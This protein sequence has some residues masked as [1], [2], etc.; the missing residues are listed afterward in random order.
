MTSGWGGLPPR[1][2]D[3]AYHPEAVGA[4]P[5]QASPNVI[6]RVVIIYGTNQGVFLYQG[7][8]SLGNPPVLSLTG[9]D[10]TTDPYGNP[11][12][13]DGYTVYEPGGVQAIFA[14]LA[15]GNIP[16]IQVGTSGSSLVTINP[17][18]STP[19]NIT[20]AIA[21]TLQSAL[22][23]TTTDTSE[24]IAG[25]LGSV[26]L[27]SG[28][29]AKM[30]TVLTSPLNS[31]TGAALALQCENDGGT[32]TA[33]ITLGTITTPDDETEIFSPILALYP[34]ALILYSGASGQTTVTKT[35]G[36]GTISGLPAT[37]KAEAWAPGGGGA[38]AASFGAA[39]AG[40]GEYAQEPALATSGSV[41]YSVGSAGTGGVNGG[42]ASTDGGNVTITGSAVTVTAHGGKKGTSTNTPGAG[43]TGSSN[44]VHY[45]GG[46]GAGTVGGGPNGAGG[47]G[48]AGTSGPGN[49]GGEGKTHSAG[50]GGAAVTGGGAGGSGG[51]TGNN[52]QPGTAPGGGGGGSSAG[53]NGGSGSRG[54]VRVTYTSGAPPILLSVAEQAG[55]DQFG[56]AY[57]AGFSYLPGDGNTY[58]S[59]PALAVTSGTQGINAEAQTALTGLSFDV[60]PGNYYFRAMICFTGNSN[61]QTAYVAMG[62]TCTASA[63]IATIDYS[64]AASDVVQQT[65]FGS[66][67]GLESAT[68]AN[69]GEYRAFIEGF[70]TVSTAGT[71]VVNGATS[72][73]A[74]GWTSQPGSLLELIPVSGVTS[75]YAPAPGPF[76]LMTFVRPSGDTSGATDVTSLG[77]ALAVYSA[78]VLL[79]GA[80]YLDATV[81]LSTA[82]TG[83][84]M[85]PGVV[86][87]AAAGITGSLLAIT[88]NSCTIS[89]I[90]QLNGLGA[91]NGT[92]LNGVEITG[93]QHCQIE[94]IYATNL[95]GYAVEAV[96]NAAACHDLMIGRVVGRNCAGGVH[97]QGASASSY[98][99]EIFI[100]DLQLQQIGAASGGNPN[101]DA[102]YLQDIEDVLIE[103]IN[104]GMVAGSG[105]C[106]DIAGACA[107]VELSNVDI[108][109]SSENAVL[110]QDTANGSPVN[111]IMPAGV[112]QEST[113][114]MT[115]SGGCSNSEFGLR[116]IDNQT[117]GVVLSGSGSNLLFQK[118][119]WNL[120]GQ[121]GT[122]T[123]YDFYVTGTATGRVKEC[124]F[125]TAIV[126][127][128][129]GPGVQGAVSLPSSGYGI[130]F[131]N[132]NFL[133]S[134]IS[135]STAFVANQPSYFR[136]CKNV[137]PHGSTTDFG[138][139]PSS[140]SSTTPLH[141]D[142][143][144]YVTAATGGCTMQR[145]TSG[146][147]GAASPSISVAA[148]TTL[149]IFVTAQAALMVT[150]TNA[151]T[152]QADGI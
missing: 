117:H 138:G 72:A 137:N 128:G 122:G 11:V 33:V 73:N 75:V 52:G 109:G 114:G 46:A 78:V 12:T 134:G 54:Q 24:M 150:Y 8:P 16:T 29:A 108:G 76:G 101:I 120:N 152:I 53:R 67:T 115:V 15:A 74:L 37:V 149:P 22:E 32:D 95:A 106:V 4:A 5:G 133:G 55:T 119:T 148:G 112:A 51:T 3:Q 84:V 45:D 62:G 86:I 104:I 135:P 127:S 107:T 34:Y 126:A 36:S 38:T 85:T 142:A 125:L 94:N 17:D 42:A 100:T 80:W 88:A 83:L 6:A 121:A 98:Q 132:V 23:L 130:P 118:C 143:W 49:A 10:T 57:A 93:A 145:I 96:G 97:L 79:P 77:A 26:L 139:V 136:N 61:T 91:T 68:L 87:N 31:S 131:T 39:S 59:G 50:P 28:T 58:N 1:R 56:T 30:T 27:N 82:S 141:Y 7:P 25:L 35:S 66:N 102:V 124:E 123:N 20:N 63:F 2:P 111:V 14:G 90:C 71:L 41:T 13:P 103:N 140:G 69:G 151:P 116:F 64:V 105:S 18:V 113:V 70:I 44:S 147:G 48:S 19:F 47:G 65:T 146:A 40:G 110:I 81:T 144:F 60:N 9:P 99:G 21:G 129:S 92:A 43:G 89:G